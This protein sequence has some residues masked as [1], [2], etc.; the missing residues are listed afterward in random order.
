MTQENMYCAVSVGRTHGFEHGVFL[1]FDFASLFSLETCSSSVA[2]CLLNLNVIG[3][4]D[5]VHVIMNEL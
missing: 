1:A 3:V 4:I 2:V 5:L